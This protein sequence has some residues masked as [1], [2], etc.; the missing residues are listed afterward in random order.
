MIL[1]LVTYNHNY[2]QQAH[3]QKIADLDADIYLLQEVK[4]DIA[5]QIAKILKAN[6][7]YREHMLRA[8]GSAIISKLP[9]IGRAH[10]PLA[11]RL[12]ISGNLRIYM[13]AIVQPTKQKDLAVGLVHMSTPFAG[14][15]KRRQQ[16]QQ[17]ILSIK[18]HKKGFI[19][20]GD[21]NAKPESR[22]IRELLEKSRLV[23]SG[24][25]LSIPTW[26]FGSWERKRRDGTPG[27]RWRR[28]IDFVFAT[29]DLRVAMAEVLTNFPA[30]HSPIMV[31]FKI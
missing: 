1:K 15:R 23:H 4:P 14:P 26:T 25:D 31:K 9:I 17:L 21:F 11:G 27:G 28:R 29:P 22:Y 2:H 24:P 30:D 3:P 20:A 13:E 6:L 7:Y 16:L 10:E 18:S 8:G 19:L 5:T 12:G